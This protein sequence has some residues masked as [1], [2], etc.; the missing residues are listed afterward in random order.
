MMVNPMSKRVEEFLS[1]GRNELDLF[2]Y[3][4]DPPNFAHMDF[5][6][7]Y[8]VFGMW[9]YDLAAEFLKMRQLH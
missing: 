5:D 1:D 2:G 4:L 3:F 6:K 7:A 9:K 8:Y